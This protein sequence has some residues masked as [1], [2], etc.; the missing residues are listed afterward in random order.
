M[1]EVKVENAPGQYAKDY[2]PKNVAHILRK[3]QSTFETLKKD[4]NTVRLAKKPWAPFE[5]KGEWELA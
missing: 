5:D 1:K 4:Q 2:N 3:T